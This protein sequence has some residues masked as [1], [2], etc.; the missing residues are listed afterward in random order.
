MKTFLRR[1]RHQE[2]KLCHSCQS[3]PTKQKTGYTQQKGNYP[4]PFYNAERALAKLPYCNFSHA[5]RTQEF[6]MTT[7]LLLCGFPTVKSARCH[8]TPSCCQQYLCVVFRSMFCG[9]DRCGWPKH[10]VAK[11]SLWNGRGCQY[12]FI[13]LH[14]TRTLKGNVTFINRTKTF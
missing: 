10:S 14:R 6:P 5:D 13:M 9:M 4:L 8:I 2:I 1:A 3:L 7:Y 11:S 12:S